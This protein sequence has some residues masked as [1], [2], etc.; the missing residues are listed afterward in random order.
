MLVCDAI[1]C[2]IT[3]HACFFLFVNLSPSREEMQRNVWL[4][5]KSNHNE[6]RQKN[7]ED[8]LSKWKRCF[9]NKI[10]PAPRHQRKTLWITTI[11]ASAA[12]GKV[13]CWDWL[14]RFSKISARELWLVKAL[15]CHL[16]SR[17]FYLS[18][19]RLSLVV[20]TTERRKISLFTRFI[21]LIIVMEIR[22]EFISFWY[23]YWLFLCCFSRTFC[24]FI[25]M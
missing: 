18:L 1:K 15:V 8:L 19:L 2:A 16:K 10:M 17:T 7:V 14:A 20:E 24:S 21:H 4:K 25:E 23:R 11:I 13:H 3:V 12:I 6:S 22:P 9:A 5:I